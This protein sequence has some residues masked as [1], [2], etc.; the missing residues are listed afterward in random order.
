MIGIKKTEWLLLVGLLVLSFVPVV[1]G[2][3]RLAELGLGT[4]I[5]FLPINPRIESAPIPVIFHLVSSIVYCILGAF[6]FLPTL[7]KNHPLWHR[8]AGR[9]LVC[10][11]V[12]SALSGLWMTHFYAFPAQLQGT[13]LYVVRVIVSVAMVIFIGVAVSSILKKRV[14]KHQ[15]FMIRAY[16]LGQGAG[17][18]VLI[19]LPWLLSVGEPE[20]FTREI[21]MSAAWLVNIAVGEWVIKKLSK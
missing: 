21:L 17:T 10:A 8:V 3:F 18:Q 5:E 2:T 4:S 13:L 9:L 20:G 14:I 7:R 16:A 6:Q 15:A 19:T 1:G 11:G 12:V